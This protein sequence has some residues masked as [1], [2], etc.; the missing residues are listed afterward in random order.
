MPKRLFSAFL[1]FCFAL[2]LASCQKQPAELPVEE[3]FE[4]LLAADYEAYY[5]IYNGGLTADSG[6]PKML[7]NAEYWRVT[8]PDYGTMDALQKRLESIYLRSET[9]KTI[10]SARDQNNNPLLRSQDGSLWRSA[11]PELQAMAYEVDDA[12]ITLENQTDSA[13]A[14]SF[15]E[16]GLDG[17]LYKTGLS[18]TKTAAGWRLDAP[19]WEAERTLIRE[20]SGKTSLVEQGAARQAAEAFLASILDGGT[21]DLPGVTL[22]NVSAW[23]NVRISSAVITKVVEELDSQGDYIVSVAVEDGG[24]VFPDG[25]QDYR[26]VMRCNEMRYGDAVY[27]AYFRPA[28]EQYYNWTSYVEQNQDGPGP[29]WYVNAFISYF[30][31][32]TFQTPWELPPETVVEFSLFFAQSAEGDQRFTPA[33]VADAIEKTFGITGFD[34]TGTKF[35]VKDQ[36]RYLLLGRGGNFYDLLIGMPQIHGSQ[37]QVEVTFYEDVLCTSPARTIRY[38]L[39]KGNDGSWMLLSAVAV[40]GE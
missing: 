35:Y 30:G 31:W 26:L 23:Q 4:Q 10:L 2:S 27:P 15:R 11:A 8:S 21:P 22:G 19:R 17:S 34:G 39:E 36:D 28:S 7:E 12:T 20:G 3:A 14:F 38:T 1:A 37:A 40:T 16:T 6:Q 25:A 32:A 13:A 5:L 18:M 33:E 9:V 24:G 29:M